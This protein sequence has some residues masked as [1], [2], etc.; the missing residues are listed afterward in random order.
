[1]DAYARRAVEYAYAGAPAA[2]FDDPEPGPGI[3]ATLM[4]GAY[5]G[6][7]SAI[8]TGDDPMECARIGA[9]GAL[10]GYLDAHDAPW[11]AAPVC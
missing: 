1:M 7:A 10:T 2:L 3:Y 11:Y 9:V 8:A 5:A 4:T 6:I